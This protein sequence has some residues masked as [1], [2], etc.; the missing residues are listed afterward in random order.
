MRH[1]SLKKNIID[2]IIEKYYSNK[3]HLLWDNWALNSEKWKMLLL[4][5]WSS[6]K[7]P[8]VFSTSG[9]APAIT[10]VSYPNKNPPTA[11]KTITKYRS[12]GYLVRLASTPILSDDDQN[13]IRQELITESCFSSVTQSFTSTSAALSV[14][15]SL[16]LLA[17]VVK[18]LMIQTLSETYLLPLN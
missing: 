17:E 6:G 15:V 9:R 10:P 4:L 2:S 18:F 7:N 12:L 3:M 11:D 8:S 5:L 16:V 13:I 1:H 14:W